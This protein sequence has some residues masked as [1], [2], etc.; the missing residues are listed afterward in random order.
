MRHACLESLFSTLKV[1]QAHRVFVTL[2]AIEASHKEQ[3]RVRAN[4]GGRNSDKRRNRGK[5]G[6]DR[7]LY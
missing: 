4:S 1:I 2:K 6:E 5:C 7:R 3:S